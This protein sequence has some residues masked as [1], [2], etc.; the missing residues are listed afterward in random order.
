MSLSK[1]TRLFS[2]VSIEQVGTEYVP[3]MY[4]IAASQ[5]LDCSVHTLA[6]TVLQLEYRTHTALTWVEA[7]HEQGP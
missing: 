1:C 4:S 6:G 3:K 2:N 5:P 7:V